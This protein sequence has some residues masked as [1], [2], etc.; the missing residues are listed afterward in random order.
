MCYRD[1]SPLLWSQ[2]SSQLFSGIWSGD[3][4]GHV[5]SLSLSLNHFWADLDV[6]TRSLSG[7][8]FQSQPSCSFFTEAARFWFKI[9][10]Y[11]TE[12]M[13]LC[14]LTKFS[15][16]LEEKQ[17]HTI[18]NTSN[19]VFSITILPF[20]SNSPWVLVCKKLYFLLHVNIDSSRFQ[21]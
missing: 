20:T 3:W 17:L 19:Q 12:S 5:K 4:G 8:N 13:M 9:S 11:F 21:S 15:G 2:L 7:W 1:L 16:S 14:I 10:W 18:T 6:C